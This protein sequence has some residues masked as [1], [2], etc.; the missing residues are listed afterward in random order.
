MD[1]VDK[2]QYLYIKVTYKYNGNLYSLT[3]CLLKFNNFCI[4]GWFLFCRKMAFYSSPVC[5]SC[6]NNF[7]LY[8]RVVWLQCIIWPAT[9]FGMR[10]ISN[11]FTVS[12]V[13]LEPCQMK[14]LFFAK[15]VKRQKAVTIFIKQLHH[16][17]LAGF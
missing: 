7:P 3:N 6:I 10:D 15:T 13:Y 8:I 1:D 9:A 14:K 12:N 17:C 11:K 2:V 5:G 16:R 4:L